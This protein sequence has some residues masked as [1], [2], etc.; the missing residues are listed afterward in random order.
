MIA[1]SAVSN[2]DVLLPAADDNTSSLR[3]SVVIRDRLDCVV[4]LNITAVSVVAD[5]STIADLINTL[6]TS[7]SFLDDNPLTQLLS[8]GNQNTVSQIITFVSQQ[9]N[10]DSVKALDNAIAS[11]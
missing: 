8:N 5:T 6:Q 1:F 2:F 7:P 9:I 3:L 10:S 11:Q 4:E